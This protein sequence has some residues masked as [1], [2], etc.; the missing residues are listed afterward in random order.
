MDKGKLAEFSYNNSDDYKFSKYYEENNIK[1]LLTYIKKD[2]CLI[3]KNYT[4]KNNEINYKKYEECEN[5][6]KFIEC[7]KNEGSND[8]KIKKII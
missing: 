7:V 5:I 2:D 8:F 1:N 4:E 3:F 6:I